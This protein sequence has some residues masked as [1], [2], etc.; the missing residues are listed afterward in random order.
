MNAL[1]AQNPHIMLS[2]TVFRTLVKKY[3]L[4]G[5]YIS[6]EGGPPAFFKH[7]DISAVESKRTACAR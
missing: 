3:C 7:N 5:R 6:P 1:N 2:K 4:W